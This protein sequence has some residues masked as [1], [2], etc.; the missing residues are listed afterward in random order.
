MKHVVAI[1]AGQFSSEDEFIGSV[2]G[3][4]DSEGDYKSSAFM[5]AAQLTELD[6]DFMESHYVQAAQELA[7][8]IV[9][10]R[11]E[12]SSDRAFG[13]QLPADLDQRLASYNSFVVLYGN[14][15]SYGAVNEVLFSYGGSR[16]TE[17]NSLFE[18]VGRF[19]YETNGF[20]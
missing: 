13:E 10:L 6:E 16:D 12:Y 5:E 9:Y 19:I 14:D 15:S 1:W 4:F 7:E 2:E 8:F 17:G 20:Q 11:H 3:T 18:H